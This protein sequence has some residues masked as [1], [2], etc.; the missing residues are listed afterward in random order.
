MVGLMSTSKRTYA[1]GLL[2]VLLLSVP[3]FLQQ[4][5]SDPHLHHRPSK[6]A[7]RSGSV[8]CGATAPLP[9]VLVYTRFCL[10]PPR[11]E[12]LFSPDLW[13]SCN[14]IPLAFKVRFPGDFLSLCQIPRLGSLMWGSESC[15]QRENFSGI[16]VLQT[17]GHPPSGY[18]I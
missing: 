14:Q 9:W 4:A 13:K 18:G 10:Y 2:P 16:T 1:K 15:Q 7:G 11:V 17:V 12:S 6:L 5:T 3:L 8:S